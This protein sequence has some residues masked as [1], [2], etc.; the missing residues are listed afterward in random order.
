MHQEKGSIIHVHE[1]C[2]MGT[3]VLI[4]GPVIGHSSAHHTL[5]TSWAP[6]RKQSNLKWVW[7]VS[8]AAQILRL[9]CLKTNLCCMLPV[10]TVMKA[11]E[12]SIASKNSASSFSSLASPSWD[13]SAPITGTRTGGWVSWLSLFKNNKKIYKT[14]DFGDRQTWLRLAT[15]GHCSHSMRQLSRRRWWVS[16]VYEVGFSLQALSRLLCCLA[17][18]SM[19]SS[20]WWRCS[21]SYCRALC[22]LRL[23]VSATSRKS[24]QAWVLSTTHITR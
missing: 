21:F 11:G 3:Y 5:V 22:H 7:S 12:S 16:P 18:C 14:Q 20:R 10:V 23:C 2:L 1:I 19:V 8:D 17:N 4:V 24:R 15:R 9:V 13:R 6:E